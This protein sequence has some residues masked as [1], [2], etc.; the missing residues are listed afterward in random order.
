MRP[1]A[2][3][4]VPSVSAK[5]PDARTRFASAEISDRGMV[6]NNYIFAFFKSFIYS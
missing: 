5:V 4:N 6:Q 1:S 3:T 2:L